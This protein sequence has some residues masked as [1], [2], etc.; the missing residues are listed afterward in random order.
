MARWR[1]IAK[2]GPETTVYNLKMTVL[3]PHS[4]VLSLVHHPAQVS[5]VFRRATAMVLAFVFVVLAETGSQ[6]EVNS[7]AAANVVA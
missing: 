2:L 3:L 6:H 5:I 7:A 4:N 1:T